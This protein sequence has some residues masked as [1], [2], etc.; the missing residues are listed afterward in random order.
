M[1]TERERFDR[2]P[3]GEKVESADHQTS[4]TAMPD[5]E[6][7]SPK[8]DVQIAATRAVAGRAIA[9]GRIPMAIEPETNQQIPF[10]EQDILP[11]APEL[12]R[13]QAF[14]ES[15]RRP[16]DE[17]ADRRGPSPGVGVPAGASTLTRIGSGIHENHLPL[18]P[19]SIAN[20]SAKHA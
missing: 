15:S 3:T 18:H 10:G 13:Q 20:R 8:S 19:S 4:E 17:P 12:L 5:E 11:P 6:A 7:E 1:N 16:G 2:R 9:I 14:A